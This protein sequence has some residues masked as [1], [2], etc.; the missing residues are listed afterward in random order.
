MRGIGDGIV[1][2]GAAALVG[3]A[4][5][6]GAAMTTPGGV[7]PAGA[8]PTAA[9]AAAPCADSGHRQFDFWLGDW[10]VENR[11]RNPATAERRGAW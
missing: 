10:V 4:I 2:I 1:T 6:S 3:A 5:A 7:G 8:A 11:Q 9:P